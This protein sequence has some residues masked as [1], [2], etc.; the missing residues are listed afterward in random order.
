MATCL[1]SGALWRCC[2][3]ERGDQSLLKLPAALPNEMGHIMK[4]PSWDPKKKEKVEDFTWCIHHRPRLQ[5]RARPEVSETRVC[6]CVCVCVCVRA[7]AHARTPVTEATITARQEVSEMCLRMRTCSHA[8]VFVDI[9]MLALLA[10]YCFT[11]NKQ[12]VLTYPHRLPSLLA[13][14]PSPIQMQDTL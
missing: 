6:V 1:F 9:R 7:R 3:A 11:V 8:P 10:I 2:N 14:A 4:S 13:S 5:K 12:V